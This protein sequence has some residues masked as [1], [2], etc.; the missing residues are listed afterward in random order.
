MKL[1]RDGFTVFARVLGDATKP[2]LLFLQGGPGNPAPRE[3]YEWI[4]HA[5]TRYR[6]VLLDQRGTGNSTRIDRAVPS[7]ISAEVLA[8]LRADSIVADA[9]AVRA[10]LGI[11]R[12]DVLGQSFGGFCL[13][14]Y[15]AAHPDS[16]GNAFFTGG[17]PTLT[18]GADEVYRATFA[19]L[20]ARHEQFYRDVPWAEKMVREVC[21]HLD[22]SEEYL[23]TGE[24]LSSRRF[25]TIGVAL[26]QEGGA[27]AL[28]GLL[29]EP[30]HPGGQL[31]TDF[32][33]EVG[34]RVSFESA[35]LYAAVH[36]S[37]YGGTVPGATS[38]AAQRVSETLEGF[39]PDA[40]EGDGELFLTGEHVF[41]F[42]FDEDPALVPFKEAAFE[43][44]AKEDWPNL[45]AQA[46]RVDRAYAMVYTDD[47]YVPRE[48]SMEAAEILGAR[49]H[50]TDAWQHD[51][52]RRHGKAVLDIL[53]SMA[54]QG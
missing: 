10:E 3:R 49:V 18:R 8:R 36:E 25:R 48:L 54:D 19:K 6:V 50:E 14:H 15:L 45:Y 20:R 21:R 31:R 11:E 23:P 27:D 42:Q 34:Q 51:G 9:E 52:L 2:A 46:G 33:A 22:N 30:F 17:L 5:L 13:A 29:E 39:A 12:W 53:F 16:V 7:L 44:A 38:W 1:Q 47:I 32:L 41:P 40:G 37:I 35:P 4:T 28:A 43:L 24:R 26:G